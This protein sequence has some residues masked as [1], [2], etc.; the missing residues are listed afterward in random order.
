MRMDG[1][2]ERVLVRPGDL[3]FPL[4]MQANKSRLI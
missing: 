4:A 2:Q 1:L 3:D